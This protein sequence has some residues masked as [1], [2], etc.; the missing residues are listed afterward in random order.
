MTQR[1]RLEAQR[2]WLHSW[3][4]R[5]TTVVNVAIVVAILLFVLWKSMSS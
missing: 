4:A 5:R 2:N 3:V 1:P